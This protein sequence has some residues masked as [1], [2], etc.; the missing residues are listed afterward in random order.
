MCGS[1]ALTLRPEVCQR[2]HAHGQLP[3]LTPEEEEKEEEEGV[4]S[5][6]RRRK[7]TTR[8]EEEEEGFYS[9]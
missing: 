1:V 9:F 2:G 5:F 8:E 4:F 3:H 6:M 7:R